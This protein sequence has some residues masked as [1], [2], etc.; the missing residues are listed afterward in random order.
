MSQ[1]QTRRGARRGQALVEVALML[2]VILILLLGAIDF[3]RAFFSWVSLHQAARIGANVASIDSSTTTPDIPA[4]IADETDVMNCGVVTPSLVYT[5]DEIPVT[6]PELGDYAQLSLACDFS[7]MTPLFGD[8]IP[9]RAA[10]AFPVRTGCVGC[11][12]GAGGGEPPPPPPEQCRTVP[13]MSN[14]S[15]SGARAAWISAGFIGAFNTTAEDTET[16]APGPVIDPVDPSCPSP[17]AVFNASVTVLARPAETEP[18][19][20]E[21]VPNLVGMTIPEARAAWNSMTFAGDFSPPLPDAD[22]DAVVTSQATEQDGSSFASDPGITC[23]DPATDPPIDMEVQV[24]D[25]WPDPPPAPCQVPH[26]IDKTRPIG[27]TEWLAAQFTGTYS[28]NNGGWK[29][30]SQ[31]LVG[32]SW[33]PC[34]SSIIVSN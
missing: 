26:L 10:S 13:Y 12:P 25:P 19:G 7:P 18:P 1:T 33:L 11:A 28:P 20:C 8:A 21:V 17:L 22:A 5:R 16:V 2:P 23:L 14:M 34:D 6:D 32:F 27:K 9:M 30:K 3:G 29:I 31:S 15:V 4:I 24:G